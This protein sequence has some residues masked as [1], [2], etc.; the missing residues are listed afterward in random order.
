VSGNI[1]GSA[2]SVANALTLGT[3]LTGTSFNGSSAVTA[4]VDATTTNTAS[5]VVARDGSGD[6]AAGTITAALAGN[7]TTATTATNLADGAANQVPYQTGAGATSFTS[8][9]S[10]GGQVLTWNGSSFT[11]AAPTGGVSQA[12]ATVISMIFG[13]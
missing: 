1:S 11:W 13:L 12:K 10:A 3:Y 6:F 9:P 2:G 8:A 5:K 7:A 4:T